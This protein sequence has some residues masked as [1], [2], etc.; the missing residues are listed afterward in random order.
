MRSR[1]VGLLLVLLLGGCG[2]RET[3]ETPPPPPAT[4]P[5][6]NTD[7]GPGGT[8]GSVPGSAPAPND[9]AAGGGTGE[10]TPS[11]SPA[12]AEKLQSL[13]V[14]RNTDI[15]VPLPKRS[16]AVV[17][18]YDRALAARGWKKREAKGEDDPGRREWVEVPVPAGPSDLYDAAWTDP[19]TGR[20][21]VLNLFHT[22]ES[23][24]TQQGTF[25]IHAKGQTPW[26]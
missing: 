6:Q 22:K 9:S 13:P 2:S 11:P 24:E 4:V 17:E 15:R 8:S 23:P 21:A 1:A 7:L 20:T 18:Y 14:D 12:A 16:L 19:K 25:E 26:K 3:Q 5:G 10:A